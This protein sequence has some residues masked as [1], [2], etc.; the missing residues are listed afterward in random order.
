MFSLARVK[1]RCPIKYDSTN[2][3]HFVVI[4]PTKEVIFHQS[5]YGLYYHDTDNRAVVMVNTVADNGGGYTQREYDGV[6]QARRALGMVG[7][8]SN[9]DFN[10]MVR[11]NMIKN[12]PVTSKSASAANEIYGPNIASMKGITT[13][14]QPE[15][16]VADYVEI[17]KAILDLN[18]DVTLTADVMFVDGIPFPVTNSR[19]IKFTTSEYVP[20]RTKPI[21]IKLLKKF[22][23]I[24]HKRGFKVITTLMDNEFAPLK[25]DLPEINL[26]S[27]AADEHVSEIERQT[28][29]IKERSRAIRST[30]PFKRLPASIIIEL[31]N[32]VTLWLNAFPSSSGVSDTFIPRTIMTGTTLDFAKHCKVPFGAYV[33]THEG[34]KP[35]NT[36][37]ERTRG[38]ICLGPSANFQGS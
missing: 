36:M 1:E 34:K 13:M 20:R 32:F 28:R 16:V 37:V 5:Q 6:K 38:A 35:T 23:N 8:P 15:P 21:L 26:N 12:C 22:L 2:G 7:Y 27:T 18:R 3:N 33:E 19:N 31:V 14:R 17:P 9:K 29:V 11:S 10:N 25:D 30:L 4:Q 24:Y